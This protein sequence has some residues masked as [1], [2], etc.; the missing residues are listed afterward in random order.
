MSS[1]ARVLRKRFLTKEEKASHK[2]LQQKKRQ[3]EIIRDRREFKKAKKER[4]LK[5]RRAK[6]LMEDNLRKCEHEFRVFVQ[7]WAKDKTVAK[8]NRFFRLLK[9]FKCPKEPCYNMN[10]LEPAQKVLRFNKCGYK[11]LINGMYLYDVLDCDEWEW[12]KVHKKQCER[13]HEL[14]NMLCEIA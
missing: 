13:A 9:E 2:A 6:Q 7:M 14:H 8:V 5:K 10:K 11:K 4:E 12:E 1:S 3:E